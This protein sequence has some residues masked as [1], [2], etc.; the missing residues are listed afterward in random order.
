[1]IENSVCKVHMNVIVCRLLAKLIDR[2]DEW[3]SV[4]I[5]NK[6]CEAQTSTTNI[7]G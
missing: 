4:W 5:D 6:R 2:V 1:M 7:V 3:I